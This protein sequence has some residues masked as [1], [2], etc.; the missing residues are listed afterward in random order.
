VRFVSLFHE[1]WDHHSDVAGGVK[2]QCALTDKP[3]AALLVDLKERG[4]LNDTLVVWGAN[5]DERRWSS[6]MRPWAALK[7][8][9]TIRRP[10][11]CGSPV[12]AQDR[13]KH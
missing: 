5:S 6:R 4:L 2:A 13:A 12:A 9:T 11:R 3:A 8:A 1:A 10:F 7:V